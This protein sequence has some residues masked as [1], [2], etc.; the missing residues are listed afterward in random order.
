MPYS[1]RYSPVHPGVPTRTLTDTQADAFPKVPLRFDIRRYPCGTTGT[2][3]GPL[4]YDWYSAALEHSP[5]ACRCALH[6]C[7]PSCAVCDVRHA[8]ACSHHTG[9][10]C[11]VTCVSAMNVMTGV[12]A[13]KMQM[14]V[15]CARRALE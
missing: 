2:P 7:G 11:S 4:R 8:G 15:C 9:D 12:S 1:Q 14:I 3:R 6:A 10:G 5:S 13:I